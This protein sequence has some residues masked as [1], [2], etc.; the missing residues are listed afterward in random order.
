M[1]PPFRA[2]EPLIGGKRLFE[3]IAAL[4][5]LAADVDFDEDVGDDARAQGAFR[6]LRSELVAV[7]GLDKVG[8]ADEVLDLVELQTPDEVSACAVHF[9]EFGGKFLHSVLAD[10][11]DAR[12]DRFVD[13]GGGARLGRGDERHLFMTAIAAL[14]LF[15][16]GGHVFSDHM[17]S[18]MRRV[19]SRQPTFLMPS[20]MMSGVRQ[21]SLST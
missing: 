2:G 21:P 13:L 5:L 7:D 12:C 10:V 19:I 16:E 14:Q 20:L 4:R 18:A 17:R 11:G 3:G 15:E 6:K 9:V 8:A 1:N